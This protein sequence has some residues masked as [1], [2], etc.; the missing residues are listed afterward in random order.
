MARNPFFE[1]C[2]DCAGRIAEHHA[3]EGRA[4]VLTP[5]GADWARHL[6][7]A[8]AS[9]PD[10]RADRHDAAAVLLEHLDPP[11]S[12]PLLQLVG[13]RLC[14]A[15]MERAGRE[16]SGGTA[17]ALTAEGTLAVAELVD[18]YT[19]LTADRLVRW[20]VLRGDLAALLADDLDLGGQQ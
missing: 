16:S 9:D 15:C 14:A 8:I 19:R 12:G 3:G 10:A 2:P 13:D 7:R 5:S 17:L 1:V 4:R 6:A 11:T 18:E 20:R